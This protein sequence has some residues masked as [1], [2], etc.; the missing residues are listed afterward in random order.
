MIFPKGGDYVNIPKLKGKLRERN[1]TYAQCAKEIG[2]S[3]TSFS[4]KMNGKSR[5]YIDDLEKI[6]NLLNLS[7]PEKVDIFLN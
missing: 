2:M 7:N 3:I 1:V 6:G 5:F 4:Q